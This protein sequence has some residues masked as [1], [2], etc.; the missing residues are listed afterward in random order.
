MRNDSKMPTYQ[1]IS[2]DICSKIA[3]QEYK[4]GDIL[5]GRTILASF[6]HVSPETVRKAINIL[7][8]EK[9][10]KLKRGVG[11]III[12][13]LHARE[14]I[15]RSN[16][17][18]SIKEKYQEL[19]EILSQKEEIEKKINEKLQEFLQ[20]S[21]FQSNEKIPLSEIKIPPTSWIIGKSVG[22]LNFYN[23]T[24]ATIV[25]ILQ[26]DG[27]CIVSCGPDYVFKQD[28]V[29]TFVNKDKYTFD[30]V[31]YFLTYEVKLD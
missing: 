9:I 23:Y 4:E 20:T 8:K 19:L 11:I 12:S 24:E 18:T 15:A 7:E 22:E 2:L 10:V 26:K 16:N 3:K 21:K 6:Y 29:I 1:Q 27:T 13:V 30:R 5:K 17:Q 28:D 25:S 31:T 14:Y